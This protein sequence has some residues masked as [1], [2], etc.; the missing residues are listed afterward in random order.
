MSDA[1]RKGSAKW[2]MLLKPNALKVIMRQ[3]TPLQLLTIENTLAMLK[4]ETPPYQ[5]PT[6]KMGG[7]SPSALSA[8]GLSPSP[9]SSVQLPIWLSDS[10]DIEGIEATMEQLEMHCGSRA[11]SGASSSNSSSGVLDQ[12]VVGVAEDMD[13]VLKGIINAR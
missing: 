3:A 1:I 4:I 5:S 12:E 13:D 10:E 2:R 9:S 11:M 7:S 6:N 8:G